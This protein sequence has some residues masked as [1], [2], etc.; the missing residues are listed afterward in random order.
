M[1]SERQALIDE[2]IPRASRITVTDG[3]TGFNRTIW[4]CHNCG[5]AVINPGVHFDW[6]R[7]MKVLA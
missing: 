4:T 3:E 1:E 6:H 2:M 7:Q 5:A